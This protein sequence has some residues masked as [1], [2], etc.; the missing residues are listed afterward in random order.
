MARDTEFLAMLKKME[1]NIE[2]VD[3]RG[4]ARKQGALRRRLL[5]ALLRRED[6]PGDCLSGLRGPWDSDR[7]SDKRDSAALV[8]HQIRFLGFRPEVAARTYGLTPPELAWM[9]TLA[10]KVPPIRAQALKTLHVDPDLEWLE[11]AR[12]VNDSIEVVLDDRALEDLLLATLENYAVAKPGRGNRYSETGGH[13]FGTLRRDGSPSEEKLIAFVS[14]ITSQMLARANAKSMEFNAKSEKIHRVVADRF[15][16]HFDCL[17]EYHTHPYRDVATMSRIRGWE[18]SAA[19]KKS[20]ALPSGEDAAPAHLPRIAIIAAVAKGG[21]SGATKPAAQ[22]RHRMWIRSKGSDG[23]RRELPSFCIELAA[24]RLL[25][26]GSPDENITL[27]ISR[28]TE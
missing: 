20:W 21:R 27:R 15:F 10:R 19:D 9:T 13:L 22:N 5:A 14:R 3:G 28:K 24:Y 2:G 12:A 11:V 18:P 6:P 26:D 4:A 16:P 1:R 7:M 25:R 17:G 8:L 23:E